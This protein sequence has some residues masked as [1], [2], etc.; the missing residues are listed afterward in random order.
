LRILYTIGGGRRNI[1]VD[2]KTDV[3]LP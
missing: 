1:V 3:Q 2:E